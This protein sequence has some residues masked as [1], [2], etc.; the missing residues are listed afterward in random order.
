VKSDL[1]EKAT[2]SMEHSQASVGAPVE[3]L[4]AFVQDTTTTVVQLM[5]NTGTTFSSPK[6]HVQSLQPTS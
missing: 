3:N 4:S 2:M 1:A 6:P 5:N